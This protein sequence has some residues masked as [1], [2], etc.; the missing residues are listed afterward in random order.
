[1]LLTT[2]SIIYLVVALFMIGFILLQRGAGAQAGS[3]F[4]SGASGTVF[5]ARGAGNF[6]SRSTA[7]LAAL[8]F[9]LSLVMAATIT[10]QSHS[11]KVQTSVMDSYEA[12][13]KAAEEAAKKISATGIPAI[14]GNA[15]NPAATSVTMPIAPTVTPT[16]STSAANVTTTPTPS[17][18]LPLEAAPAEKPVEKKP[19]Q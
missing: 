14:P 7:V 3:G 1:M 17:V 16:P 4:G 15:V 8:F 5:G 10:R 9:G 19:G 13:Q 2:L 11:T 18:T 12:K 6:L